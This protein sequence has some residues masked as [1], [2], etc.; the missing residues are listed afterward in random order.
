[1]ALRPMDLVHRQFRA[2]RPNQLWVADFTC[3]ATW[4]GPVFVAFVIDVFARMIVGWRVSTSMK[5]DFVLDALEQAL[6]ARRNLDGLIHHSDRGTQPGFNW[7]SQQCLDLQ[8]VT[9]HQALPQEYANRVS[10]E[11]WC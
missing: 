1:M 9:L 4:R 2:E 3:V 8:S 10:C 11:V 5:T 7:S 6:H